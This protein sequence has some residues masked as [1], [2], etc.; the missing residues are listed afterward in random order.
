MPCRNLF[1]RGPRQ[2]KGRPMSTHAFWNLAGRAGRWGREFAGNIFCIQV[3]DNRDWPFGPPR[4]PVASRVNNAGQQVIASRTDFSSFCRAKA[5]GR[6]VHGRRERY[7]EQVLGELVAAHLKEGDLSSVGWLRDLDE[8]AVAVIQQ[9]VGT[10]LKSVSAP[11]DLI[12]KHSGIHPA[13]V[14]SLWGFFCSKVPGELDALMPMAPTMPDAVSVL[15]ANLFLCDQYLGSEF[16]TRVQRWLKASVAVQWIRGWPLRRI[17][18]NRLEWL[19]KNGREV[20][21]PSEIRKIIKL[22]NDNARFAIPKYM[23]CYAD[24]FLQRCHEAGRLDLAADVTDLQDLYE[25]G[26]A[27]PTTLALIAMGLS[28]TSAVELAERIPASKMSIEDV[29]EWLSSRDLEVYNISP[30][31]LREVERA[32]TVARFV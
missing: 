14:S 10:V 24:C 31:I 16:G 11:V 5:E 27:E 22:I 2:G 1:V 19:R 7:F 17:I 6:L 9:D 29:V 25:T 23:S 13:L 26:V 28:R 12:S 15:S 4:K 20:R 8:T 32:L 18:D 3:H 21:P 30:V